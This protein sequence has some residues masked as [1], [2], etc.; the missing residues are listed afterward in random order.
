MGT[1]LAVGGCDGVSWSSPDGGFYF[2]CHLP[3]GVEQTQLLSYASQS[4]VAYLPGWS[5]FTGETS[6]PYARL[7]FSY[8]T[9]DR[10]GEGVA[11]FLDAVRQASSRCVSVLENE[12]ETPPVV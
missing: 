9:I 12:S 3:D 7:N 1:A 10:I 4:R 5:C 11:R 2:W 8:P 6:E